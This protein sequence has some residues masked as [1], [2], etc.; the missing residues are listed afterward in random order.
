MNDVYKLRSYIAALCLLL[1]WCFLL[2]N[3]YTHEIEVKD[4]ELKKITTK[5][6]SLTKELSIKTK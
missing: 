4:Q 2:I 5:I 6:D 1:L 3:K